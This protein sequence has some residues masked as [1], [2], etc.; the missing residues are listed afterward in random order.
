MYPLIIYPL[1]PSVILDVNLLRNPSSKKG[2]LVWTGIQPV[3]L[4][5]GDTTGRHDEVIPKEV[6]KPL[7]GPD[8]RRL[9]VYVLRLRIRDTFFCLRLLRL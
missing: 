4:P 9:L 8:F 5:P 7:F 1:A 3:K 6:F 2:T